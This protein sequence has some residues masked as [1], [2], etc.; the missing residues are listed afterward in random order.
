MFV[1]MRKEIPISAKVPLMSNSCPIRTLS[2]NREAVTSK[3]LC[4]AISSGGGGRF[5]LPFG[6]NSICAF[7]RGSFSTAFN[8]GGR[9]VMDSL[10]IN[11]I[12]D[13]SMWTMNV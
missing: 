4:D 10:A 1:D 2:S 9:P 3:N 8:K 12:E 6:H 13:I 11:L 7:E 5:S